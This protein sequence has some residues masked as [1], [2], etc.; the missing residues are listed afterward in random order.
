MQRVYSLCAHIR[1][2]QQHR[3]AAGVEGVPRAHLPPKARQ[4]EGDLDGKGHC[5]GWYVT[6][7]TLKNMNHTHI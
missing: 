5:V 2:R 1:G 3:T 6:N 7:K 4:G